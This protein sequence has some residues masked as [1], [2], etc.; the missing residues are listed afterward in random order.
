MK[1][2]SAAWA[3][4]AAGAA[5]A[6][7]ALVSVYEGGVVT[8]SPKGELA[9]G[10]G[11]TVLLE[12]G[13]APV[14]KAE[15][16]SG[17]RSAAME[18]VDPSRDLA[19]AE[20]SPSG[21]EGGVLA[22]GAS[23]A[24]AMKAGDLEAK[25][26]ALEKKLAEAKGNANKTKTY[27]LDPAELKEMAQRCELRWD[28]VGLSADPPDFSESLASEIGLS[29][30]ERR[31]VERAFATSHKRAVDDVRKIYVEVTGDEGTGSLA[32]E[33]MFAEIN[34]K[35]P[36]GELKRIFQKLAR[37]RAGLEPR[38]T[39]LTKTGPVERMY[40]TLTGSGDA[41]ESDLASELGPESARRVRDLRGGFNSKSRSSHGCPS[42]GP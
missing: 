23:L 33:A 37:E 8:A 20:G 9:V 24:R 14:R 40:R 19:A 35:A 39:D 38:P 31:V 32:A 18:R 6:S 12:G 7:V 22:P 26:E 30:D 11:E 13:R 41:L 28:M 1:V 17:A 34:D 5:I 29:D 2:S 16:K 36:E 10:A 15:P 27:D 25:I 4:T 42:Y 21:S 3:G